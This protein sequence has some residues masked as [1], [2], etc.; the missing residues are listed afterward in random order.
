MKRKQITK[1][2]MMISNRKNPSDS[3]FIKNISAFKGLCN[4]CIWPHIT[5]VFVSF[6]VVGRLT[7]CVFIILLVHVGPPQLP[8]WVPVLNYSTYSWSNCWEMRYDLRCH[9]RRLYIF[10]DNPS[11]R[12]TTVTNTLPELWIMCKATH[13]SRPS[14]ASSTLSVFKFKSLT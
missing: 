7:C 3:R 5:V 8:D 12:P 13:V 14:P 1:T 10:T 9:F 11:W 4:Q 2:F 6:G